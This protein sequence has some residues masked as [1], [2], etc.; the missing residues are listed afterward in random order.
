ML[1]ITF[2]KKLKFMQ[3]TSH[4]LMIR[5]VQ[6]RYNEQTAENNFYQKDPDN[7]DDE[8][9]G[10]KAQREFD[11]FVQ[12]LRSKGV[13]VLVVEDTFSS[14]TPDSIFPNNW[15]SFHEDGTVVLFPMF[16]PNRRRER[17]K[18]IL[19]D[20]LPGRGF[21]VKKIIDFSDFEK[22]E[23]FLEAT[24]SMVMDRDNR[25]IYASISERTD[26]GLVDEFCIKFGYKAVKFH[27][28]QTYQ[29]ER[30]PI[31]HTNVMMTLADEFAII[32]GDAVDNKEELEDVVSNLK[33]TGKEIIYITEEQTRKFAGNMLQVINKDGKKLVVMSS[34]AYHSLNPEQVQQVQHYGELVHSDLK[35]IETCGGGSARC[36]MAEVFLPMVD[37]SLDKPSELINLPS[38]N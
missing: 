20:I 8:T 28:Y 27:S 11:N 16:A 33:K 24:G 21:A 7:L 19:N 9:A 31:Y 6:F 32:C 15:V 13:D 23:R 2:K 18:D 35:T 17:R 12:V 25:I 37:F 4:I 36:M 1:N 22:S 30:L 29:G 14:D 26:P 34:A 5:P 10:E 3:I 38:S